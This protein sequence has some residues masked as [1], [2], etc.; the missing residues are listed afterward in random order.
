MDS[1]YFDQTSPLMDT[2]T[3]TKQI[4]VE[5]TNI[6]QENFCHKYLWAF[7]LFAIVI[8]FFCFAISYPEL[9]WY[10]ELNNYAWSANMTVMGIILAIIVIIMSYC[11]F[12]GYVSS[13]VNKQMILFT[14]VASLLTLVL[15]FYVFYTAKNLDNAFYMSILFLFLTF[16][17]TYYVWKAN[18][19]A[20]Y[21]MILYVLWA[22]FAVLITWNISTTNTI[23]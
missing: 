21:G 6:F 9:S 17:Q 7:I 3:D 15:W 12:R 18:V 11:T 20:G 19:R 8:L 14:F 5:E 16:I 22:I 13:I 4:I 2:M 23:E 10:Q 1:N